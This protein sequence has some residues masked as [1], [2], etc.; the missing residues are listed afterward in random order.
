[1]ND[2]AAL[3]NRRLSIIDFSSED[4]SLLLPNSTLSENE[5]HADILYTPNSKKFED[6]TTKL[7]QWER[8]PNSNEKL[9]S[10]TENPKKNTKC[11]LR[12]S[13]AWDSAFFT[14]A[15]FLDAK[16]LS[17]IIEGAEK[18]E[19]HETEDDL[20]RSCES[21]STLGS[22][23]LTLDESV[24][25]DLFEDIRASIQKS[26][27]KSNLSSE[28]SK[29]PTGISRLQIDDS[30]KKVG[31][32]SRNK[33]KAPASKHPTPSPEVQGLGKMTKRT[34]IFPQLPQKAVASRRE[35]SI[36]RQPK[37]AGK[38]SS[39]P[40]PSSVISAKRVLIGD[41]HDKNEK[42]KAKRMIGDRASSMSKASVTGGSRG[43]VPKP[44]L[45]SRSSSGLSVSAKNKS[46]TFTPSA[47]NLPVGNSPFNSIKRKVGAGTLKPPSSISA[48]RTPSRIASSNKIE[49][50][51]PS[52]SRLMSVNKLSSSISPASSVSDW[53]S[54]SSSST[55]MAKHICNSSR[56]S[57]DSCSSRKVLSDTEADQGKNYQ[58]PQND[59]NLEGQETTVFTSQTASHAPGGPVLPPA[60]KKPSGLRLPSPKIGF[61]DGVKS[62]V[63]TPR[64]ETQPHSVIP[65][66]LPKHRA[67]TPSEGQN[68][69]KLRKLE[70]ASSAVSIQNTIFN[71]QKIN[72]SLNNQE[73]GH[74]NSQV[75]C[76]SKQVALM[77]INFEIGDKFNGDSLS[78]SQSDISFHDKSYDLDLPSH[79]KLL[80]SSSTPCLSISP[81]SFDMAASIRTPF[82][83]RD[84]FCNMDGSIFPE[85]TVSE[86]KPVNLTV[87]DIIM[88]ENN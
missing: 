2:T 45:P 37:V 29:V 32:A 63:R 71:N 66:S 21:I 6:A 50:G 78:F 28:Y 76:L 51:N 68:K 22:D 49:T 80:K 52:L 46:T 44:T 43:N 40:S 18:D 13:L 35:S 86:V 31:M 8:E 42:D 27:K 38:S 70:S 57:I 60:L 84:S 15:G 88:K 17:S 55:F 62:S 11:N 79:K 20:Y 59:S 56:T 14:S 9:T 82:A 48:V 4:D 5:D 87:L 23:S 58:I 65:R 73:T 47:N 69:E 83:V 26:S 34:P 53:S 74:Y 85:S 10:Q 7:E 64:G 61:F 67:A 36:S 25:G 54:E 33:M 81:T 75:D 12:K 24:E 19:K 72:D 16:E 39:S 1:M 77:D 30:S 3:Q 41:K